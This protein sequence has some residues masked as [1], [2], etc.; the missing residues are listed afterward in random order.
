MTRTTIA[1]ADLPR[2]ED[3][4]RSVEAMFDRIAGR[5][6]LVNRL[7]TFRL[8]VRWRHTTVRSLGLAPQ[9]TVLDI[10]C[11]TGDL[12]RDLQQA[13]LRPVGIDFS[14]GMLRASR[15]SAPL[16]R[17]DALQLPVASASVDGVTCGFGLRNFTA[18]EEF[19]GETARVLRTGG[20]IA[21]LEIAEPSS[22]LVR[23]GHALWFRHVVPWLGGLIS[24]HDAYRYLPAST[25][26][27]PQRSELFAMMAASG[28]IGLEY[29]SLG[30]GAAQ[31]ITGTRS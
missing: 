9:T 8:D 4:A 29:R 12:C 17:A 13:A 3:K 30:F 24:D 27:L 1:P 31:L 14:I 5:Y 23:A 2:E 25:Y 10:A 20:R 16:L 19:F 21:V 22:A 18:P 11:G 15:T 7:I 26:Y 6:D 28:F